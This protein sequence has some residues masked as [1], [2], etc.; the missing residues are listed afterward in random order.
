[1]TGSLLYLTASRPDI[2]FS[3]GMCTK[4]KSDPKESH[5]NA[6]ERII[7]YISGTLD[8]EIWYSKDSN[9]S[10]VGFSAM[11][12][13]GNADDKKSKNGGCFYLGNNL[14]SWYSKKKVYISL[15]TAKAEYIV[16]GSC[17]TQLL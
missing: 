11:D 10:L 9:V 2:C 17:C 12:W 5:I 1:M 4:Y 16:V 6:V 7:R 14:I 3:V 13:A 15:S 8:Y